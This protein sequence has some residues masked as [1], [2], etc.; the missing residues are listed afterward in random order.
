MAPIIDAVPEDP[1]WLYHRL[2]AADPAFLPALCSFTAVSAANC[3][4]LTRNTHLGP[5]LELLDAAPETALLAARILQ[6]CAV[7]GPYA[8]REFGRQALLPRLVTYLRLPGQDLRALILT[9]LAHCCWRGGPAFIETLVGDGVLLPHLLSVLH[10]LGPMGNNP[11]NSGIIYATLPNPIA[12]P[13][14]SASQEYLETVLWAEALLC[15]GSETFR[16]ALVRHDACVNACVMYLR[17]LVSARAPENSV[18]LLNL[19]VDTEPR[20]AHAFR[21]RG[22][23]A[24]SQTAM[25]AVGW[26]RCGGG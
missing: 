3:T 1:E 12:D 26:D 13:P 14:R 18:G 6:N 8:W 7:L 24:R 16:R 23:T 15:R 9:T 17:E 25:T 10:A 21:V 2:Q 11:E 4:H 5:L 20:L 22:G 19:L